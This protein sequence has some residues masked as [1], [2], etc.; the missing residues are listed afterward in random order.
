MVIPA[1]GIAAAVAAIAL[2]EDVWAA[3]AMG[4][5]GA[6]FAGAIRALAGDAPAALAGAI[7]APLLAAAMLRDQGE[8]A[9]TGCLALAAMAWTVAELVRPT[10]TEVPPLVAMAPATI[11][12]LLEP[13]FVVL[14]AIA[15]ARAVTA[16]R[17]RP[18]WVIA[19]PI[20]GGLVAILA[21]IA[22]TAH[23]GAFARLAHHWFA[24]P[25]AA[26]THADGG[27]A[28]A[29]RLGTALGPLAAVATL[30]GLLGL[31]R[32][33]LAELAIGACLAGALLVD[34]RAG[35]P[36]TAAIGTAALLAG[37]AV[38]SF[39]ARI[40]IAPAQAVVGATLG[41]LLLIPPAW[42]TLAYGPAVSTGATARPGP[43]SR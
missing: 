2:G 16:M 34:L 15:G 30:G 17:P 9:L 12:A 28:A 13:A 43:R 10:P 18:R 24:H 22:G 20:V 27:A 42:S 40:R 7:L 19:L 8:I 31:A 1:M 3:L 29:S 37:L 41:M 35:T 4:V 6:A 23:G 33:R 11:A 36:G 32:L 14:V 38:A 21:V 25:R 5:A 26:G 39:A